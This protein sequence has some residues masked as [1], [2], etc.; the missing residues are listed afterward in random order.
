MLPILNTLAHMLHCLDIQTYFNH[1]DEEQPLIIDQTLFK[2]TAN[3]NRIMFTNIAYFLFSILDDRKADEYF[4]N[5]MDIEDNDQYQVFVENTVSWLTELS[6][7]FE[8]LRHVPIV[9]TV[10]YDCSGPL[11]DQIMFA[12]TM[13]VVRCRLFDGE[14]KIIVVYSFHCYIDLLRSS[15]FNL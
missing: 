8:L 9:N 5:I 3:I 13:A 7:N 14:G 6:D 15:Y 11:M 2:N 4:N 10:F 12:F 1:L